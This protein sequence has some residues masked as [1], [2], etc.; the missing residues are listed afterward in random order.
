MTIY[1]SLFF[2]SLLLCFLFVLF[3]FF[4]Y[5]FVFPFNWKIIRTHSI[6]SNKKI[7]KIVF[8]CTL[9]ETKNSKSNKTVI[10]RLF[11]CLNKIIINVNEKINDTNNNENE[12]KKND[13]KTKSTQSGS[14]REP[15]VVNSL[16]WLIKCV[17]CVLWISRGARSPARSRRIINIFQCES[18]VCMCM[19]VCMGVC[20]FF[21][22]LSF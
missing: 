11:F 19:S 13:K 15:L 3:F 7:R 4:I 8:I 20:W 16:N 9:C 6:F 14:V 18:P 5:L 1:L 2:S 22:S 12:Q 21:F 10:N 17:L